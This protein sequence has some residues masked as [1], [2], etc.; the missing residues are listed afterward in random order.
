MKPLYLFPN[1]FTASSIFLG[2]MGVFY[3]SRG[4]FVTAC[5]FVVVCLVLD[6]LDGRVARLTNTT[7]KFGLEFD[8]LAD[9]VAFGAAPSTI[10]YFYIGHTYGRVGMAACALFVIFGAIRLARFNVTTQTT[11]PYSFIGIPIPTGAVLVV[12]AIL[13]DHKY[14][15]FKAQHGH[16]MLA[17]IVFLGVMMVSNIRYPNFKKVCWNLKLFVLLLLFLLL[18]FIKPLEVLSAFM[19][20]YLC[21]GIVRWLF[22]MGKILWKRK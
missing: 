18:L 12:L 3:A 14:T 15:L 2:M 5:W 22:V 19:F 6:G 20:S 10:A 8:S 21:Y 11:D 4:S 1:L 16:L 13:L 17:Y 7:S 9:V